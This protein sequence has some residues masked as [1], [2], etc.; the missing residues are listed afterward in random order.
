MVRVH[1]QAPKN[2]IMTRKG[3]LKQFDKDF[4]IPLIRINGLRDFLRE[5]IQQRN[6]HIPVGKEHTIRALELLIKDFQDNSGAV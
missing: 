5:K 6:I 2:N 1:P 4:T 3:V